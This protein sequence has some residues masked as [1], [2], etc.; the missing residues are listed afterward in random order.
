MESHNRNT[1]KVTQDSKYS[2]FYFYLNNDIVTHYIINVSPT[3]ITILNLS[4]N[5]SPSH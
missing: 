1:K 2:T 4:A 5:I 3:F